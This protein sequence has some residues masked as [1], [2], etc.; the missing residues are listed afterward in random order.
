MDRRHFLALLAAG[1]AVTVAGCDEGSLGVASSGGRSAPPPSVGG[2]T[3]SRTASRAASRAGSPPPPP[4]P[5][6]GRTQTD[7]PTVLDH[8]PLAANR[9]RRF[10][11]TVDD[12]VSTEVVD[13]YLDFV[14]RTGIRLTF[15]VNGV[16]DSWTTLR[17]KLAPLVESGQIQLGNHTWNHPSITRLGD[18][19]IVWQ[20]ERNERFLTGTYGV[21]GRPY[22]RPPYGHFDQRTNR[23]TGELGFDRTVMW[24][25]TLGDSSIITAD[26]VLAAARQWFRA[27]RIVIGHANHSAVTHIYPQ[28]ADLLRERTL[29]TVTLRD[30]FGDA[31][32]S[33]APA[34]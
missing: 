24:Y 22:F 3:Q 16:Y 33:A 2:R 5:A 15:F 7:D 34:P 29:Q 32:I 4:L 20:L 25:G 6:H 18:R 26:Q 12:G 19:E 27:N 10:A 17:P 23:V 9:P 14:T 1:T 11:L 21:S 13:A 30:V 28:L 31:P 8:L